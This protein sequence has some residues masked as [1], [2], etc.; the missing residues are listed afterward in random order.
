MAAAGGHRRRSPETIATFPINLHVNSDPRCPNRGRNNFQQR[1][2]EGIDMD[3]EARRRLEEYRRTGAG[4]YENALIDD[5]TAGAIDRREL[6]RRASLLGI[7]ASAVGGL[8]GVAGDPA[9]AFGAARAAASSSRIKVGIIPPPSG[10]IEPS[11]I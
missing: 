1:E 3:R 11:T 6:L 7:S 10:A 2:S 4:P 9:P 5:Y 8:L